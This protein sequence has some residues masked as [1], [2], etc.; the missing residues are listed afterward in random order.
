MEFQ[1]LKDIV[2]ILGLSV[3]VILVLHKLKIPTILGFLITGM[4]AG[5]YGFNLI[6]SSHEVEL[7]S[8][9]GIIFLLF[10]IGIEFSLK[11]MLSIRTTVI[12]GGLMQVGGTICA[13]ALITYS[14]GMSFNEA[15]FIGF[16]FA[17]SSTAIVLK[18]LQEKG[19]SS[20]PH[21]RIL[22]AILIFQDLVVVPMM[23]ITPI[24][25]GQSEGMGK[26]VFLLLVKV[27]AVI[28]AVLLLGRFV[29]PIVFRLVVKTKS[30]ELFLLTVIVI[31]FATAWFTSSF[32]LSLALGAFFA[33]LIISESDYS[34]QATANIQPFREIFISFFFVSIGMLLNLQFFVA[35]ILMIV[36]L[37]TSVIILK[38][39]IVALTVYILK[40]PPR[41]IIISALSI[42][43]VGEFAFLLSTS[44][45]MHG[46]LSETV[47]QYFLAISIISM[48][49][50]PFAMAYA[51]RISDILLK[52]LLPKG[53]RTRLERMTFSKTK[54]EQGHEKRE[55][56]LVIIGYGINGENLAKAAKEAD[57][58][59]VIIELDPAMIS[60]AR[61]RGEPIVFGDAS[62]E[63]ILKHIGIQR[64]RVVVVAI[65]D[66]KTTKRIVSQIRT[67]TDTTYIIVRTRYVKEIE[68][69]LKL[70]ADEVIPEEFETSVEI[71]ARVLKKYLVPSDEIQAFINHIR[72][73]NYE[74]LRN[75]QDFKGVW[76]QQ[77]HIPDMEIAALPVHQENNKIVGRSIHESK[78]RSNF[79]ITVL[80]IMREEI[81]LSDVNQDTIIQQDDLLY[82]FGQPSKIAQLN[83][84]LKLS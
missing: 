81:F 44:G 38:A 52:S 53:I 43:Q 5:P 18:I 80:A 2:I 9:M 30:K 36:L 1:L 60:K 56:H 55:N 77:L 70:G 10:V 49:V 40:Y 45:L 67:F 20:S 51:S 22:I 66:A 79:G 26:I 63:T 33:G 74:M 37:T 76:Q 6:E 41:I 28:G 83:E 61:K 75:L 15:V 71:F 7:L 54:T 62:N 21:G 84:F 65:S 42:F 12:W 35:N 73:G 24:L 57:I 14:F 8:E 25:T 64:S 46:L 16:L 69:N 68:E 19:E 59:Y 34:H 48:G 78:L 32:G 72:E 13:A 47:Y 17:L 27:V 11:G 31:C 58:P 82:L 4:I 50:T 23:L 3:L 29:I 39:L